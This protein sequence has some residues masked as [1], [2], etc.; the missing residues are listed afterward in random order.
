MC[1]VHENMSTYG[2]G[3][4]GTPFGARFKYATVKPPRS[5]RL[6]WTFGTSAPAF[7]SSAG[8][9]TPLLVCGRVDGAR[10]WSCA[11]R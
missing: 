10:S 6:T 2:Q 9:H 8:R 11:T 4:E 3:A 5:M 1:T 7:A